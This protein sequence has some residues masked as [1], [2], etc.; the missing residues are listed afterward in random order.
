MTTNTQ[1]RARVE[2]RLDVG[3]VEQAATVGVKRTVSR[4]TG[5]HRVTG[6]RG[7][8]GFGVDVQ[9]AIG[10]FVVAKALDRHWSGLVENPW[11]LDGDVGSHVQ[12][13]RSTYDPPYLILNRNDRDPDAYVLVVGRW[14]RYFV[15]GWLYTWEVR[16]LGQRRVFAP[17]EGAKD[18]A[19]VDQLRPVDELRSMLDEKD[20][21]R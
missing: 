12:V 4:L 10:E 13:R 17:G 3:E 2:V 18:F 14:P 7:D 16:S 9:G 21:R 20:R 8:G 5:S 19:R 15:P 11:V 6:L 1:L